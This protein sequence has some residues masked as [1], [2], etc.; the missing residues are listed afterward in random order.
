MRIPWGGDVLERI[1]KLITLVRNPKGRGEESS[2]KYAPL[3]DIQR[4]VAEIVG[5][6][7]PCLVNR[8]RFDELEVADTGDLKALMKLWEDSSLVAPPRG[9]RCVDPVFDCI[10][11]TKNMGP[12]LISTSRYPTLQ[13]HG[14]REDFR[15]T[16]GITDL[17]IHHRIL[18]YRFFSPSPSQRLLSSTATLLCGGR[19]TP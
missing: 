13:S 3:Q 12:V 1:R 5:S 4:I 6:W 18:Y 19:K 17:P 9:T 10:L 7:H 2:W 14:R 15:H 8:R 16:F 11:K